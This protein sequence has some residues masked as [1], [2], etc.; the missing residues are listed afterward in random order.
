MVS[1]KIEK[2][3]KRFESN[4][5]ALRNGAGFLS[6]RWKVNAADVYEAR[7]EYRR[8]L[9]AKRAK[10]VKRLFFDIETAP[11]IAYVWET[12]YKIRVPHNHIIQERQII[13]I[14]YK[15]WGE[16]KVHNLF[17][18]DGNDK[19]LIK[20]FL[21]VIFKADE[22]V[23]FNGDRF[24]IP[25][26]NTR[27]AYHNLKCPSKHRSFDLYKKI[28]AQFKLNSN[29]LAY[30]T[31]LFG[32]A[33]KLETGGFDLW[34][35]LL[36]S[37]DKQRQ[38]TAKKKMIEYCNQDVVATED[39]YDRVLK[40]TKPV[41]NMSVLHGGKKWGCPSCGSQNVE[42]LKST[43]TPRGVTQRHMGCNEC[44][45]YYDISSKVYFSM[46]EYKTINNGNA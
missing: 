2:I 31:K 7:D 41:T 19:D 20:E 22:V 42:Y 15:W 14:S 32:V 39:L 12:G 29:S 36:Q 40:Y 17:W 26:V 1:K 4:P 25:F 28:K 11:N 24:D 44:E 8:R 37:E 46:L 18:K 21:S 35:D 27:A 38:E 45:T 13:C 9:K 33:G 34:L 16:D 5:A 10:E 30:C 6:K 23:T 43:T 3:I